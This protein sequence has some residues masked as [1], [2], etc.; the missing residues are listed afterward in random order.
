MAI[1]P[2]YHHICHNLATL[3]HHAYPHNTYCYAMAD[4]GMW[5]AHHSPSRTSSR[6]YDTPNLDRADRTCEHCW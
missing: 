6:Q 1:L 5:S 2:R 4:N 3:G